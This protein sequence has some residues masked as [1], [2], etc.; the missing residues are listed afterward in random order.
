MSTNFRNKKN[1][2][3]LAFFAFVKKEAFHILRDKRTLLVLIGIPVV[4]IVLFGF[5]ITNEV[6]NIKTAIVCPVHDEITRSLTARIDANEYFF[7]DKELS[8]P[9]DIDE[10]F[11][12]DD[13]DLAICFSPHLEQRMHSGENVSIQLIA[14]ATDPNA[15]SAMTMYSSSVIQRF[16]SDKYPEMRKYGV[17]PQVELLYNPQMKSSYSFVPGLMGLIMMLICAMM[18]SVSIVR[19]KETGTMEVLL[20][21]PVRPIYI[22]LSKMVPYF[23]LSCV[24]FAVILLLSVFLLDVPVQ[25]SLMTL[26]SLLLLYVVVTLSLGLLISNITQTQVAAMLASGMVLMMPVIFFSGMFFPVESMPVA[27]QA[28]SSIVPARWFIMAVKKVMI[29]G[30]SFSYVIKEC[31]ILL[32]MASF[33]V[34]ISLR[35]FKH[36]LG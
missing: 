34:F 5:A 24:N 12:K 33:F 27:L 16:F 30:L 20:V 36:R 3:L 25:G 17:Q 14:D 15:A 1:T 6:K 11:Q 4:Q 19:E 22:I 18:T 10:A 21:S 13:M 8:S 31:L 26:C 32:L 23:L 28:V 35:K 9:E 7:V 29:E 2:T